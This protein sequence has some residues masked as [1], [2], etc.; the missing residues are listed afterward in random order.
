MAARELEAWQM[1]NL[2]GRNFLHSLVKHRLVV[3]WLLQKEAQPQ[4]FQMCCLLL[5]VRS[6]LEG[7]QFR[8]HNFLDVLFVV[9]GASMK[10]DQFWLKPRKHAESWDHH[11]GCLVG[12]RKQAAE[13]NKK[14]AVFPVT[15][16]SE[17]HFSISLLRWMND[18]STT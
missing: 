11:D 4:C 6:A 15:S 5:F 8:N 16:R 1:R 7:G 13:P 12:R 14:N 10:G 2:D 18:G 9:V 17:A 3:R